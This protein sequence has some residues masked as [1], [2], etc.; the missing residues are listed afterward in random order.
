MLGW[1]ESDMAG[2]WPLRFREV[3]VH[4]S[5]GSWPSLV[6]SVD[7]GQGWLLPR[8]L[9]A[10]FGRARFRLMIGSD[11][12]RSEQLGADGWC[13]PQAA[14]G[15]SDLRGLSEWR[16]SGL[17]IEGETVQRLR[18]EPAEPCEW[19][20]VPVEEGRV[21]QFP[22]DTD[23]TT[24]WWEPIV[25]HC[26][27]IVPETHLE[28]LVAARLGPS[29]LLL[30]R[31]YSDARQA[32]TDV[33]G[34]AA[35]AGFW[36]DWTGH[37]VNADNRKEWRARLLLEGSVA[38]HEVR[39]GDLDEFRF[40]A[41]ASGQ[42]LGELISR[43]EGIEAG[44]VGELLRLF[45][46]ARLADAGRPTASWAWTDALPGALRW[47]GESSP[48]AGRARVIADTITLRLV[49]SGDASQPRALAELS[50]GL[51]RLTPSPATAPTGTV[52]AGRVGPW[53]GNDPY[54]RQ[55]EPLSPYAGGEEG[56][57]TVWA[58]TVVP[59]FVRGSDAGLYPVWQE[60][61]EVALWVRAGEMPVI[62][63]S[64]LRHQ[65]ALEGL[66]GIAVQASGGIHLLPASSPKDELPQVVLSVR[67][68]EA[69]E[70]AA[71]TSSCRLSVEGGAGRLHVEAASTTIAQA[72]EVTEDVTRVR[73]TL[74][75]GSQ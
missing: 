5:T 63:G 66:G 38:A 41:R 72:L 35:L 55:V 2:D 39:S 29:Q 58:H 24:S 67:G 19:W 61:D 31:P 22:I 74:E 51:G 52:I 69:L 17:E 11:E 73:N 65:P 8:E 71:A 14:V 4:R 62:L 32:M 27:W 56:S 10:L 7:G 15:H 30:R 12:R 59:G 49:S 20:E 1:I 50:V 28:D 68:R 3:A 42:G 25:A 16:L 40:G 60:G 23:M 18:L 26:P 75:T 54:L 64:W 46:E 6:I 37:V 57:S 34:A 36:A 45:L 47:P 70:L 21:S 48:A 13:L 33:I 53:N 43:S 44:R 9:P